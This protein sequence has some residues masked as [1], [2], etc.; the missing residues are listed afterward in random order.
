LPAL[1]RAQRLRQV[2]AASQLTVAGRHAGV[3][4]QL[5]RIPDEGLLDVLRQIRPVELELLRSQS[6]AFRNPEARHSRYRRLNYPLGPPPRTAILMSGFIEDDRTLCFSDGWCHDLERFRAEAIAG[7][8]AMLR[9]MANSV[10]CRGAWFPY[11]RRPILAL[12]GLPFPDL[13]LLTE[14]DRELLWRAFGVPVFEHFLGAANEVLAAECDAHQGLHLDLDNGVFERDPETG[15][16]LITSLLNVWD[17]A[18][19]I[20]TGLEASIT[21]AVCACGVPGV[22]L[23]SVQPLAHPALPPEPAPR[24][25]TAAAGGGAL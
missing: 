1:S 23:L 14:E 18:L 10:F 15:E 2:L 11:L 13:G 4:N 21:E 6:A 7:P 3:P 8:V 25:R 20:R 9:R 12:T 19:R 5:E 16:L 17:P 22:R 24:V